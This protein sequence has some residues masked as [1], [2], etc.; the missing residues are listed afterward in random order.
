MDETARWPLEVLRRHASLRAA[1]PGPAREA[2]RGA[3]WRLVFEALVRYLRVHSRGW[4]GVDPADLEDIAADKA[5]EILGRAES[6]A[7]NP[8]GRSAA[9]VAGYVSSAARFGWIDFARRDARE[10]RVPDVAELESRADRRPH[11]PGPEPAAGPAERAEA[12][13]LAAALRECIA[14]L[15]PR[16][17]RVWF[18]RAY[19]DLSSREIAAHPE[20]R[21]APAHVDVV[22]QRTREALARCLAA[23]GHGAGAAPR[24]AFVELWELLESM[25]GSEADA[26]RPR[27]PDS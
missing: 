12:V 22:M 2:E 8:A 6:G 27:G 14:R 23:R 15:R 17:R 26:E 21:L 24:G 1:P 10:T 4:S 16:D 9:E 7:W 11:A 3:L 20:V 13:E 25:A 18:L 5:L 19:H